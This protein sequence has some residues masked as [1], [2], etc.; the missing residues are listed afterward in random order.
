MRR[1]L[2]LLGLALGG[3]W[4]CGSPQPPSS[5]TAP[6]ATKIEWV[7]AKPGPVAPL[8]AAERTRALGGGH[9]ALV[10]VGATWCEPCRRFHDAVKAGALDQAFAGL[11]IVEFDLDTDGERLRE[12]GYAPQFIPMLALPREDGNASGKHIEGSIKGAGA[13]PEITPRLQ[14]LLRSDA[15]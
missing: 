7:R 3:L 10:Y 12:A 14:A 1:L 4:A 8:V 5:A 15:L 13:V 9:K 2:T 11:R 6:A